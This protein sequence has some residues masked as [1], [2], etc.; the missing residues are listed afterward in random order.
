MVTKRDKVL[1][2]LLMADAAFKTVAA[3][4]LLTQVAS[5]VVV[6]TFGLISAA[7]SAATG[8]YVVWS[9]DPVPGE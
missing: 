5:T 2:V 4:A 7:T 9:R 6:S 3:S 8:V 1:V